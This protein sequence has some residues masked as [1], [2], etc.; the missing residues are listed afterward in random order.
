MLIAVPVPKE[1]AASG[2]MIESAIQQ[3]LK[4]AA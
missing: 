3:A 2:N 1:Y 4:E